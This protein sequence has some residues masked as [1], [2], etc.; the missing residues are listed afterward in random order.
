MGRHDQ[1]CVLAENR[2]RWKGFVEAMTPARKQQE[3]D[4]GSDG[5][6]HT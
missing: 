1:V 3:E 5:D 6:L 4:D 2:V